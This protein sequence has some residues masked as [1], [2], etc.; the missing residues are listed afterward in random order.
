MRAPLLRCTR[1]LQR[2]G[3]H[4]PW[5]WF[6]SS[7]AIRYLGVEIKQD[8]NNKA[9]SINQQAYI[10][11]LLRAHDMQNVAHTLLPTPREWLEAL[12]TEE[13]GESLLSQRR[14]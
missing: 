8:P 11:D 9:F 13:G 3:L 7:R 12:E 5:S 4:Q 14:I 1:R 2:C 6:G 10:A